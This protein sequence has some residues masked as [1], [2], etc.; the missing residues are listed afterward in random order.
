VDETET[1]KLNADF[2]GMIQALFVVLEFD[3]T[4]PEA[5][6]ILLEKRK[7]D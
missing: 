4:Y 6:K 2:F 1:N 3:S 5:R 7:E